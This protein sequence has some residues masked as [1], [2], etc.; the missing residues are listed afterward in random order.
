LSAT[1]WGLR[2]GSGAMFLCIAYWGRTVIRRGKIERRLEQRE[3][4]GFGRFLSSVFSTSGR[5]RSAGPSHLNHFT[6]QPVAQL[7]AKG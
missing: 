3:S 7:R 2:L 1:L 4:G 6:V 5:N